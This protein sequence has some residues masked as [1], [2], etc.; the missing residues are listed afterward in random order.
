MAGARLP[1]TKISYDWGDT[2]TPVSVYPEQVWKAVRHLLRN[3]IE[4]M[5]YKGRYRYGYAFG[6]EQMELQVENDGPDIPQA[7]RQRIFR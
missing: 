7:A 4:A 6:T 5:A 3:A 1:D 2:P